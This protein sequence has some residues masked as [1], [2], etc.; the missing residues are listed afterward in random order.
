MFFLS[1][2]CSSYTRVVDVIEEF[3]GFGV[4]NI[5]LSGNLSFY[6]NWQED[7]VALKRKNKLN[8][9]VH[10]YF[11][12]PEKDA[13]VLNL[14]SN[15]NDIKEKSFELIQNAVQLIKEQDIP[16]YSI[17]SGQIAFMYPEVKNYHF[18]VDKKRVN[19]REDAI[20]TFY[21]NLSF[22][23]RKYFNNGH[24]LAIENLFPYNREKDYCLLTRP[25]EIINFMEYSKRYPNLGLLLDLGHLNVSAKLHNF[26]KERF[27]NKILS[28]YRDKIFELHVSE[29]NGFWDQHNISDNNSWQIAILKEYPDII[30]N[31]PIVFEWHNGKNTEEICRHFHQIEKQ[32]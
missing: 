32:F 26:S 19:N 24:K 9:L 7:I 30:Q 25:P 20:K 16:L 27:A 13:F 21:K 11:P 31:I 17:H 10:G 22:I 15:D 1:S 18:V 12:P 5:E 14:A 23:M 29:N 4:Y 6:K 28:G 3:F 8:L 2:T